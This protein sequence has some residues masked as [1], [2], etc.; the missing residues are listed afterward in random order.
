M[1]CGW[2]RFFC[3]FFYYLCHVVCET[4]ANLD[5]VFIKEVVL[6]LARWILLGLLLGLLLSLNTSQIIAPKPKSKLLLYLQIKRSTFSYHVS[7]LKVI[8]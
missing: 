7:L 5:V 2:M 1:Y 8:S 6:I 3:C 4:V